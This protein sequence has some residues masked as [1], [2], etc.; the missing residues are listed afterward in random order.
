MSTESAADRL[1][2]ASFNFWLDALCVTDHGIDERANS[3]GLDLP[4]S[5][6][7]EFYVF[8]TSRPLP[9]NWQAL[10]L[11]E[12]E[13]SDDIKLAMSRAF[14]AWRESLP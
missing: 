4:E 10:T 3:F 9:D 7:E 8:F 12:M 13:L 2:K 5:W 1:R 11:L 6:F 14:V